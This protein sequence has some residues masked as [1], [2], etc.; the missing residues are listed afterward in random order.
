MHRTPFLHYL[1]VLLVSLWLF[2]GCTAPEDQQPDN[3]MPESRMAE[4]L[5]EIHLAESR[6]SRLGLGS[7]D[8]S[9]IV[10]KRLEKQIFQKFQVDTSAYNK[11]YVYYSSHPS[12][13]ETIYK[14]IT[15]NLRKK[16]EQQQ[17]QAHI[18][19]PARS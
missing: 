2:A 14:H 12:Q 16:A 9:N 5:T 11:S 4:I 10:Y 15:E 13:M 19:K 8:S 18:K 1:P 6:V 3:L 7:A 17:K